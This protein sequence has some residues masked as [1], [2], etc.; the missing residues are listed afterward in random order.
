M[1]KHSDIVVPERQSITIVPHLS[2]RE[3]AAHALCTE[4]SIQHVAKH[5][6][7]HAP[8]VGVWE[9]QMIPLH[10][11]EVIRRYRTPREDL[12]QLPRADHLLAYAGTFVHEVFTLL[13]IALSAVT[14][15][16]DHAYVLGIQTD[17]GK[18]VLCLNKLHT[19]EPEVLRHFLVVRR[20]A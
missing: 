12:W 20:V 18:R 10:Q 16:R 4:R 14:Y 3:M 19:G 1:Q 9:F 6:D 13:I 15:V 8:S 11:Y 5:F 2:F 17:D 7:H